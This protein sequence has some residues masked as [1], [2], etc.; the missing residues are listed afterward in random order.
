MS[1]L[2]SS[3]GWDLWV[4]YI[5]ITYK[6][7]KSARQSRHM[8]SVVYVCSFT[9][10]KR[11]HFY[12]FSSAGLLR[13]HSFNA[14]ML[15]TCKIQNAEK[16]KMNLSLT[17]NCRK[18]VRFSLFLHRLPFFSSNS[19]CLNVLWQCSHF[20][21]Y[22]HESALFCHWH[23][24]CRTHWHKTENERKKYTVIKRVER[25]KVITLKCQR[26]HVRV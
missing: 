14:N 24:T 3:C 26:V 13:F 25:I 19:S 23:A 21:L 17:M 9:Y 10:T 1:I 11:T 6:Q 2:S 15:R 12:C 4:H 5:Q 18:N 16:E 7:T 22:R 8:C 20:T